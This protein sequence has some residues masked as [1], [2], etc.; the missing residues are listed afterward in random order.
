M[1]GDE[2]VDLDVYD[3]E[4]L[5]YLVAHKERWVSINT[6]ADATKLNWITVKRHLEKLRKLGYVGV[7]EHGKKR[8]Y[9]QA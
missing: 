5:K 4:I 6:I 8:E 7:E 1:Q 3:R 2:K 9:K